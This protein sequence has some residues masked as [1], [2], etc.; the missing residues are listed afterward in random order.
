MQNGKEPVVEVVTAPPSP[1]GALAAEPEASEEDLGTLGAGFTKIME[2]L[3]V[4]C[5][6][7]GLPVVTADRTSPILVELSRYRGSHGW[8]H[9]DTWTVRQHA[10]SEQLLEQWKLACRSREALTIGAR[11]AIGTALHMHCL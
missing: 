2:Q 7:N 3:T 6:D 10:T 9:R 11:V 8:E 4:I 1:D 5:Q